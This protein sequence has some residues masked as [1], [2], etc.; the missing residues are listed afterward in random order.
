VLGW[1]TIV[2]WGLEGWASQDLYNTH[3]SGI[4]RRADRCTA[5]QRLGTS[6]ETSAPH[7][8]VR[9]LAATRECFSL[10]VHKLTASRAACGMYAKR[11][12]MGQGQWRLQCRSRTT[13]QRV[14]ARREG[15][16][17]LLRLTTQESAAWR[18]HDVICTV[19]ANVMLTTMSNNSGNA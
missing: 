2:A 14:S 18:I 6:L 4:Y 15:G 7:V 12:R 13:L 11:K 16:R 3:H 5:L 1:W 17:A 9:I 8:C 19:L 10:A